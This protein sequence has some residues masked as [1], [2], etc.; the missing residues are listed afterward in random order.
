[1]TDRV[2]ALKKRRKMRRHLE[3]EDDDFGFGYDTDE[4]DEMWSFDE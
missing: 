4:G 2:P 3:T 1:M